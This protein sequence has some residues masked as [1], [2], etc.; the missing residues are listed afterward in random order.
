MNIKIDEPSSKDSGH[1]GNTYIRRKFFFLTVIFLMVFMASFVVG[2]YH[3]TIIQLFDFL[4]FK[5]FNTSRDVP[6]TVETVV[7]NLRLPRILAAIFIGASLATSGAAYQGVFKNPL[8]SPDILGATAGA[9]FGASLAIYFSLNNYGIQISA[10]IFG[11]VSVILVFTISQRVRTDLTMALVLTG[12]LVGTLF[13]SAVSL[14]KYVV[15]PFDKLPAITFWLM[16]GLSGITIESVKLVFIPMLLNLTILYLL[17]WQIN[18]LS[19]GDEEAKT[20]GVNTGRLRLIIVICSTI[21]TATSVCISGVIGWIGLVIP[22]LARLLIGSNYVYLLPASI[23]MGGT[24]LL[25][26]DCVSRGLFPVEVP[27]GILTAFIGAPFFI[28]LL[29]KS[30]KG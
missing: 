29:Y 18:A 10:F 12:M 25:I 17:R 27:L 1:I 11:I 19:L 21:L 8:A 4:I 28:I 26:V 22:N 9:S 24:F 23:I 7:M 3:L 16:G 5:L 6:D 14:I 2:R 13:S 15:D 30:W 20:L